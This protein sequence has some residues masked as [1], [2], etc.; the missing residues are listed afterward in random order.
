MRLTWTPTALR[1]LHEARAFIAS[2]N[3]D[4]AEV[5][6]EQIADRA[7]TLLRFPAAGRPEAAGRR[8]LALP[9]TPYLLIYRVAATRII[10][11]AVWHGARQWPPPA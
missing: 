7:Q 10:I 5:L 6:I 9:P 3:P 11:L 2:D 8:S 4:A 1:H